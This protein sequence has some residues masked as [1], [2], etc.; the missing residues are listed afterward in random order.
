MRRIEALE[1]LAAS[2]AAA[3]SVTTMRA[4]S[5]WQEVGGAPDFNLDNRTCMGMSAALGLGIAIAQPE[6]RVMVI[7]GD[8]SLLMQLGSLASVAGAAPPNVYHLVLVNGVYET[9]GKQPVPAAH[10]V[11][12]TGLA[13]AAGY[14]HAQEIGSLDGLRDEMAGILNRT[15]PGLIALRVEPDEGQKAVPLDRPR[16]QAG[17]LRA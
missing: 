9:T 5:D 10:L 3:V 8:G 7:D 17:R 16:D 14:R 6:R 12:F 4:I 1:V 15:G 13:R 2:K 11:D